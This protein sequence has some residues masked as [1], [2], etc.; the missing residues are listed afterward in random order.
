[1]RQLCVQDCYNVPI[2]VTLHTALHLSFGASPN[3]LSPIKILELIATRVPGRSDLR[4]PQRAIYNYIFDKTYHK[5]DSI[6]HFYVTLE[7]FLESDY[8]TSPYEFVAS[9]VFFPASILNPPPFIPN[10]LQWVAI[11]KCMRK[12][13][14]HTATVWAKSLVNGWAT[15]ERYH[16]IRRLPCVFG[17][18]SGADTT[19]HYLLCPRLWLAVKSGIKHI[20]ISDYQASSHLMERLALVPAF[21]FR[22]A[23]LCVA[24]HVY[25]GI[26]KLNS[27]AILQYIESNEFDE[28]GNLA[29]QHAKV[30]ANKFAGLLHNSYEQMMKTKHKAYNRCSPKAKANANAKANSMPVD[31]DPPLVEASSI[32]FNARLPEVFH[33]DSVRRRRFRFDN[34]EPS[35][36]AVEPLPECPVLRHNSLFDDP[37]GVMWEQ[38][39]DERDDEDI[40][41]QN[42]CTPDTQCPLNAQDDGVPIFVKNVQPP[43]LPR[44]L[45]TRTPCISSLTIPPPFPPN[46]ILINDRWK[47]ASSSSHAP[48]NVK[49]DAHTNIDDPI[50]NETVSTN[51]LAIASDLFGPSWPDEPIPDVVPMHARD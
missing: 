11:I 14:C 28:V 23:C 17:C 7:R 46:W 6:V 4:L 34:S 33:T 42:A 15:S 51:I 31:S 19:Y 12:A 16:E 44:L 50:R 40:L 38:S 41:R 1:M 8:V 26:R 18:Y 29:I 45:L 43:P 47:K 22:A 49:H 25:H 21:P 2:A 13:G 10:D 39:A 24:F 48:R 37:D 20:G 27:Q 32:S 3:G 9:N 30:N 35:I 36:V 5:F